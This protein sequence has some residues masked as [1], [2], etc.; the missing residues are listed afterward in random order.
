MR[1]AHIGLT[2]N[3]RH[4]VDSKADCY[5]F[6]YT[7]ECYWIRTIFVK[8]DKSLDLYVQPYREYYLHDSVFAR[9]V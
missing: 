9:Y 4:I 8:N 1:L 7:L 2:P 6:W 5:I 3:V